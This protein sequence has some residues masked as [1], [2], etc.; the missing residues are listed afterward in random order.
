VDRGPIPSKRLGY[1]E[2]GLSLSLHFRVG[3]EGALQNNVI[4]LFLFKY[5]IW[6]MKH[7]TCRHDQLKICP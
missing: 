6:K 7:A 5:W 1:E 4:F 3:S 2:L